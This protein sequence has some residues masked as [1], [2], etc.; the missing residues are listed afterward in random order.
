MLSYWAVQNNVKTL[1]ALCTNRMFN[2]CN[3]TE[4][5]RSSPKTLCALCTTCLFNDC[6]R[7]S[8]PRA[9]SQPRVHLSTNCLINDCNRTEQFQTTQ[10][11]VCTS[12]NLSIWR[13]QSHW[14][15][16]QQRQ[17]IVCT[18]TNSLFNDR[19]RTEEP[20]SKH[21]VHFAQIVKTTSAIVPSS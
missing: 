20:T 7:L 19:N 9:T 4:P 5:P 16:C 8:S 15:A 11:V 18:F 3:R 14:A 21:C 2:D 10:N 17:N 13:R 6:N 1:C 12:H